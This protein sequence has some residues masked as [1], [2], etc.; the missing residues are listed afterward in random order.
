MIDARLTVVDNGLFTELAVRLARDCKHPVKYA[1]QWEA[2]FPLINDR[3]LGVGLENVIRVE[4]PY[5]NRVVDETDAFVF[6]DIFHAGKQQLLERLGKKVWGS[7]EG[8]AFETKRVWFRELQ[9]SLG[10][11]VPDYEVVE[12]YSNLVTHLKEHNEHCFIKVTSKIRGTLETHEFFDFEEDQYWIWKLQTDLGPFRESILF[13]VE[14]PIDSKFETGIDTYCIDGQYPKT[15]MQGIEIKGQLILSSA[16]THSPTPKP[17]DDALSVLSPG[18]AAVRYR[19]FLSMEFRD[20]K[21]TDPC[22]RGAN[23]GLGV[24]MEMISNL[25]DIILAGADGELVEPEY[26]FEFGIQAAIFHDHPE[27]LGK[28]FKLPEDLRRWV[29]LMEFA[30]VGEYYEILPRRPFG[31]KIGWL[32]GVGDTIKDAAAHLHENAEALKDHPFDIKTGSLEEAVEQAQEAEKAGFEF[33]DQP[34]PSPESV[35]E[36]TQ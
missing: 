3:F 12:G 27:E 31:T 18:M 4:D 30:K 26:E 8:D 34:I 20:D 13:L 21:L 16:Q 9:A 24:K 15:P 22:A 28:R 25:A 33:S 1:V 14:K 23:P 6:P 5:L 19:N 32:L 35:T 10:I 17:L 11:P 29:K 7:R 2:E 36:E